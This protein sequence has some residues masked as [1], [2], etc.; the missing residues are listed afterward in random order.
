[1][2]RDE[3]KREVMAIP[4]HNI[5][6]QLSTGVGKTSLAL[7]LVARQLLQTP[8]HLRKV[9]IVY[10]KNVLVN[11]WKAEMKK[12]HYEWMLPYITFTNYAS[13][14]KHATEGNK[15]I[16][17]TATC[18]D[19]CFTGD[20]E[21][22]TLNGYKPFKDLTSKDM[23]AQWT[24][25][26]IIEFV[27]PTRIIHRFHSGKLC[28]WNLG[29]HRHV[30]L[31]PN[32]NQIYKDCKGDYHID[33]IQNTPL[34]YGIK[35]PVSGKGTGNNTP[36]TPLERLLIAVQA[37]GTLQRH[38]IKESVYSIEV[39]KDRKKERLAYLMSQYPQHTKIKAKHP[40]RDRYMIKFPKGDAKL[41][42]THFNIN[43]GYD[44]ANEFIEEIIQWDGSKLQG[45]SLYYSSKFK[46]NADFV[47]A[48]AV[49]A[50]YKVLQGI[51]EDSRKSTYSTMHR[52]YMRKRAETDAGCMQKSYIDYTGDV[53][54]VE[55]PSHKI[56]VRSEGYT[57]ITGNCH[58]LS[59]AKREL[60]KNYHSNYN[61]LLSA[62][63][64][65]DLLWELKSLF[66]NL[67]V[68]KIGIK[69]AIEEDILP[70]PT[71]VRIPLRLSMFNLPQQ[72]I[73]NPKATKVCP[74]K[75]PLN[76]NTYWYLK[77]CD[78]HTQYIMEGTTTEYMNL[79]N[80][81]IEF[82]KSRQGNIRMRNIWLQM[83][84]ARL[85]WLA[86]LKNNV[87]LRILKLLDDEKTLTFCSN[88]EQAELLS[89]NA[90]HSG[91]DK[92]MELKNAF[93]EG[94]IKHISS[95]NILSEGANLTECKYGIWARYNA[96]E[97]AIFQKQGRILRH[98]KPIMILPYFMNTR[99]EELVNKMC[100]GNG[101][102][103]IIT[104]DINN[105]NK[106]KAL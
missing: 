69:T 10:P 38:Q 3:I 94:K 95:I 26:G 50:G 48:V 75:Y 6:L 22:L 65:R 41:L 85:H 18:W 64:G 60:A 90:I 42:S 13:L 97:I 40:G 43:M 105:I 30:Y 57:F 7:S 39:K 15:V 32:H 23:V 67:Y 33:T 8:E 27:T 62:T 24:E 58:H 101:T 77:K 16:E 106:I 102:T 54:C 45:N 80:S 96:S 29:R 25:E 9:L 103:K 83:C 55:V 31:T 70:E 73:I 47:A 37:D 51:E 35:I 68:Y 14:H 49:Q 81:L 11:D 20:T 19:E 2:T 86:M 63:I 88:I 84:G 44:R 104:L 89:P 82:Y 28:K 92:A 98:K 12:W 1:M 53:Y 93:N 17:Y 5:L 4:N 52:V 78:K 56:V 34:H 59:A 99:E 74:R 21:I 46:E 72:W 61:I 91:N 71:I 76:K 87:V 36:L 79:Q 66:P 100:E